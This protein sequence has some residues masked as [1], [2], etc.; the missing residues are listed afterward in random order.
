MALQTDT[1]ERQRLEALKELS[2]C[3]LADHL[4]VEQ[5]IALNIASLWQPVPRIVGRA[6]TVDC[7]QGDHLMFHAAIYRA[8]PGDIIV[9]KGDPSFALAGGNVFAIAKS[10]GIVG[11]VID[12]CV[13]DLAEI[14]EMRFPVFALG[15]IPKPGAKKQLGQLNGTLFCG[16]VSVDNGDYIV[17]DEEGIAVIPEGEIE[18]A[19][20]VAQA[21]AQKDA[22][23]SLEAWQEN[24]EK[25]VEN[26]LKKL[27]FVD[28]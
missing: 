14:R 12:G 6:F 2:P 17:A 10:R 3:D 25:I 18:T 15:V 22:S 27:G 9:A 19:I 11:A 1:I 21:R 24:H 4:G 28:F 8:K 16:N 20:T 26:A 7:P 5:F 23:T 13:R